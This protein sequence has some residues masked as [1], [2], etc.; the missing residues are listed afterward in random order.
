MGIIIFAHN[1]DANFLKKCTC[2]IQKAELYK[3]NFRLLKIIFCSEKMINDYFDSL[4]LSI[5]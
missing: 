3:E 5:D 4:D 1:N 2:V